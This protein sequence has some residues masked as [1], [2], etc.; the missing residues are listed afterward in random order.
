MSEIAEATYDCSIAK[1][2]EVVGERWTFLILR[3]AF[4]GVRRFDRIQSDLG[5]ARNILSD[6]LGKLVDKGILER[7]QY[8]DRPARYEY[9]LTEKG[10]DLYPVVVTMMSWGDKHLAPSG[11]PVTLTHNA[12]GEHTHPV[13]TCDCCG[14]AIHARNV[15]PHLGPGLVKSA[16]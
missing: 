6:R 11:P 4:L 16:A 15:T 10:I 13:L 9:R 14:E 7:R 5:I 12:C 2:L 8:Q 1:T 3:E